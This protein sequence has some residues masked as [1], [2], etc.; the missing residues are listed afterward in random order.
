M[1]STLSPS[2]SCACKPRRCLLRCFP[3]QR[4]PPCCCTNRRLNLTFPN[5]PARI[6][7]AAVQS[8]EV[9]PTPSAS[10]CFAYSGGASDKRFPLWRA[11]HNGRVR[12]SA[13]QFRSSDS[14]GGADGRGAYVLELQA[15]HTGRA[16]GLAVAPDVVLATSVKTW[17][18]HAVSAAWSQFAD[19]CRMLAG[20]T[21]AT[22]S[23][24]PWCWRPRPTDR[25]E[26]ERTSRHLGSVT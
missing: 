10:P 19:R 11:Q 15:R 6:L 5:S 21:P 1:L 13:S 8:N 4:R 9:Y 16:G 18:D 20:T 23:Q 22:G 3:R 25:D 17:P 2:H 14:K 26:S 7:R 12:L 24:R